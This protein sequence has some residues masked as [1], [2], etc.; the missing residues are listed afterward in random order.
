[1]S[2]GLSEE[3]STRLASVLGDFKLP[4]SDRASFEW[5]REGNLGATTPGSQRAS[6]NVP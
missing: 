5:A 3:S 6:G 1:M 4:G 2:A